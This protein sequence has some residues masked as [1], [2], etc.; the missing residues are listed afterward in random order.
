MQLVSNL[1]HRNIVTLAQESD[2]GRLVRW[3]RSYGSQ[4][5]S[6]KSV[7]RMLILG[8]NNFCRIDHLLYIVVSLFHCNRE[9]NFAFTASRISF[10]KF[11]LFQANNHKYSKFCCSR[12]PFFDSMQVFVQ[13]G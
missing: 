7:V 4:Y 8:N 9:E 1:C 2:I 11:L 12:K 3:G 13:C 10:L 6:E 5:H